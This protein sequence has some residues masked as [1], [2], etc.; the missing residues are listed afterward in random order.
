MYKKEKQ[1][2]IK[3]GIFTTVLLSMFVLPDI[4]AGGQQDLQQEIETIR[5]QI[6]Q[7][8]ETRNRL[9]DD[10]ASLDE[11]VDTLRQRLEEIGRAHV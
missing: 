2:S 6:E 5:T 10:L 7:E 4:Y 11:K 8:E 9:R 3:R 1:V